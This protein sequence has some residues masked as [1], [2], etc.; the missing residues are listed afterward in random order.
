MAHLGG[1]RYSLRGTKAP[2]W[3]GLKLHDSRLSLS[4]LGGTFKPENR[5]G[6]GIAGTY[7]FAP[8]ALE[9]ERFV[10]ENDS[11]RSLTEDERDMRAGDVAYIEVE[12]E[13]NT[14]EETRASFSFETE[15][16]LLLAID[17]SW[18]CTRRGVRDIMLS[19]DPCWILAL[20][21]GARK[22]RNWR[23]LR[24]MVA[25]MH[26][27]CRLGVGNAEKIRKVLD[28]APANS[29][30]LR[31]GEPEKALAAL[32][33]HAREERARWM[34]TPIRRRLPDMPAREMLRIIGHDIVVDRA[35]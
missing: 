7:A 10:M 29:G 4:E 27:F 16:R 21:E 22:T 31:D 30:I 32:E 2:H 5:A 18:E 23:V 33:R 19:A 28:Q 35:A 15:I 25:V 1:P 26:E 6:R 14:G 34:R 11:L 17:L 13:E 20:Y 24:H 8:E 12:R 3:R 9:D